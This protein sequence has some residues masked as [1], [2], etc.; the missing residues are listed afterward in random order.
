[1]HKLPYVWDYDITEDQFDQLLAGELTIG[2]L[3][4]DWAAVR[5]L[6]YAPYSEI[7][8]RLGFP[9][10]VRD[11][12]VCHHHIRSETVS[13]ALT[14]WLNGYLNIILSFFNE[15]QGLFF[16]SQQTLSIARCCTQA[17]WFGRYRLLP[18][19]RDGCFK[20]LPPPSFFLMT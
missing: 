20:R 11:W 3:N 7:V 9:I 6:E 19:R 1:M 16:L 15:R 2:R 13:G 18:D 8:T 4:Q 14:F 17:H 12:S 5:L 10:L